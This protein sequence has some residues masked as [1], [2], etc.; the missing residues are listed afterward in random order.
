[1]P[2][3]RVRGVGESIVVMFEPMQLKDQHVLRDQPFVF[4]SAVTAL[5]AQQSLIP[6]AARLDVTHG[7]KRLR[8]HLAIA[9]LDHSI[10][11][12]FVLPGIIV[13]L[14]IYPKLLTWRLVETLAALILSKVKSATAAKV[15]GYMPADRRDAI[16]RRMLSLKPVVAPLAP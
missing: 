16:F 2:L 15:I 1:M 5:A 4:R 12:L 11:N 9:R 6:A 8:A 3:T 7:Y 14:S 13:P 10:K